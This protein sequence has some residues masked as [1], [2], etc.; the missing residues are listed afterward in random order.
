MNDFL[1]MEVSGVRRAGLRFEKFPA[2]AHDRLLATLWS[3]EKRLEAAVLAA[4][5]EKSGDLKTLTGGRVYDHGDRIA[6]VVGVNVKASSNPSFN[7]RKA[8]TLEYGNRGIAIAVKAHTAK[9][10]HL[11]S[12]AFSRISDHALF[13]MRTPTITG[14][15]FLRGPI[16][17]L[18][19]TALTEMK[20]ALA[21]AAAD[22]AP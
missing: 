16:E 22:A 11:W 3:L 5:P 17:A 4:E 19:A 8:A 21:A 12:R 9:L 7:A 13:Y 1:S 6:A 2:A 10:D 18:H 15:R 20:A 14:R